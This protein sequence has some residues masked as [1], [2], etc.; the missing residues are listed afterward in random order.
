MFTKEVIEN[1]KKQEAQACYQDYDF[2]YFT[3]N[4]RV[5]EV[6]ASKELNN[7]EGAQYIENR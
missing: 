7:R 1:R 6:G 2:E 5:N 3:F 4:D